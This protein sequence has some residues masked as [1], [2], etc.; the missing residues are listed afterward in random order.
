MA[1]RHEIKKEVEKLNE[2]LDNIEEFE[3]MEGFALLGIKFHKNSP[4]HPA[5]YQLNQLFGMNK[6]LAAETVEQMNEICNVMTKKFIN[7]Q[8]ERL[9][10]RLRDITNEYEE[11]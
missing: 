7:R 3:K 6:D 10:M 9:L 11:E 2:Y 5:E 8:K 1:R 4:I